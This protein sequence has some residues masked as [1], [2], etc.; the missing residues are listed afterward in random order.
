MVIQTKHTLNYSTG[1]MVI[2]TQHT[3]YSTG[4][5]VIN[6]SSRRWTN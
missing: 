6:T 2:Q 5:M 4:G 3:N 1:G